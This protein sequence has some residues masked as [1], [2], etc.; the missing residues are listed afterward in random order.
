MP[1]H[2][3]VVHFHVLHFHV[4]Q[5]H[6]LHFHVHQLIH[7]MKFRPF[8]ILRHVNLGTT[9]GGAAP[10]QFW[11]ASSSKIWRH[12]GQ[13]QT[14]IANI[15]GMDRQTENGVISYNSPT[16]Y[17]KDLVNFSPLITN[18]N[19]LAFTHAKSTLSVQCWLMRLHSSSGVA[20][21]GVR[22]AWK[23]QD[24]AEH[25]RTPQDTAGQRR[26]PL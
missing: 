18:F 11:R 3:H 2:F 10:V 17:E 4:L 9:F 25:R 1:I 14:L 23:P 16:F 7:A 26:T 15:S 19:C 5:F 21:S 6:V 20:R 22:Y 8:A 24:T 12:F 13:L